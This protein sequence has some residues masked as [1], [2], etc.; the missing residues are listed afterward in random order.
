MALSQKHRSVLFD[1]VA[2]QVGDDVAEALMSEF[3]ARDGDEV[4]TKDFLRAE[5]AGLRVDV[6]VKQTTIIIAVVSVWAGVIIAF[7]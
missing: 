5:L 2:P 1:H 6:M 7:G 3:P 4:V